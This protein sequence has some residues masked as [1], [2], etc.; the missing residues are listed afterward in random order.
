MEEIGVYIHIPFCKKKCEYC[1]FTSFC[2]QD[3]YI[4]KYI[5]SLKKEIIS[6]KQIFEN[7]T[8]KTIY[9]GGGTPSYIDANYI[10]QIFETIKEVAKIDEKSEITIEVN[11]GTFSKEKFEVYKSVGINRV[12]IGLQSANDKLLKKIGRIHSYQEFLNTYKEARNYFNNINVDLM[13]GLPDQTLQDVAESLNK[14][15]D[16]NPEHISVYSLIL[17]ENTPMYYKEQTGNLNLP[18]EEVER[19]MYWKVKNELKKNNYKHYEI[20]NFAK[21][22]FESKHNMDCWSQKEY[23]GFGLGASSYY[24]K[25]RFS[26]I[27]NM[28][29]YIKNI[30]ENNFDKNIIVEEC[31]NL[32]DEEKEFILLGLRKID[33]VSISDFYNKFNQKMQEKFSKEIEKLEKEKLIE[34]NN[35]IKL[36]SKGIDLANIVWEEFI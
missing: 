13:I 5:E 3:D 12:S 10:K 16:L 17:E 35:N 15:I 36:T 21:P 7:R 19:N 25:Q 1:D 32:D 24:N 23:I 33:G 27:S 28:K 34:Q 18:D 8:I 26:N 31:Q 11:P 14:V 2:N 6:K 22:G 4:E 20:S 29:E 30:E 9:V